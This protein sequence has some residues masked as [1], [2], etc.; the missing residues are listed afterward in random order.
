[1]LE[2][3]VLQSDWWMIWCA[4]AGRPPQKNVPLTP[5][6]LG[7]QLLWP[8]FKRCLA[9]HEPHNL[10]EDVI[11]CE[12]GSSPSGSSDLHLGTDTGREVHDGLPSSR[13]SCPEAATKAGSARWLAHERCK[14]SNRLK[15]DGMPPISERVLRHRQ[16]FAIPRQS[17]TSNYYSSANLKVNAQPLPLWPS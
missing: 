17:I 4:R 5:P 15:E 10:P 8:G 9:S 14:V 3:R 6:L 1:M 12:L 16:L 7:I 2:A 11:A 13:L